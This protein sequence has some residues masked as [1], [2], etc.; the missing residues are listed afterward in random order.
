M[1][2]PRRRLDISLARR[3]VKGEFTNGSATALDIFSNY[4]RSLNVP[5]RPESEDNESAVEEVVI[6]ALPYH[7]KAEVEKLC[8]SA[9]GID[10]GLAFLM[11]HKYIPISADQPYPMNALRVGMNRKIVWLSLYEHMKPALE[12]NLLLRR[13]RIG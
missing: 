13:A 10:D 8:C 1:R 9:V 3:E 7:V 12:C 6:P 5:I 11:L 2:S 4:V